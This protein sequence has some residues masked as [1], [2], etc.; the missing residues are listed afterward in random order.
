[1]TDL[2]F[3]NIRAVNAEADCACDTV[4]ISLDTKATV[5]IGEFS[6]NGKSRGLEA[7]KA[8]D[9]DMMT[10]VKVAPGGILE[11]ATGQ[12]F[13]FF[14]KSSKTSDF[15]A[16]GIDL[17]W[18][19][20][21]GTSEHIKRVVINMDNGPECSG[22]RS[23]F[24]HRMVQFA[25]SQG[26]EVRLVYYPPY[27]SKYNSIEHYW[28]GLERSWNGYLLDSVETVLKRASNFVWRSMR[29]MTTLLEGVYEKGK[30][31]CGKEKQALEKRLKRSASLPLYD[32]T[33][34]PN[35]VN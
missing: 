5:N 26:I 28:G 27:H 18:R 34:K 3:E 1:L 19:N 23:Q 21:A 8:I 12:P 14:T 25:D 15:I 17:W 31:V 32:I 13:V 10:K 16:D 2:I 20:R 35:M 22:R 6:R 11:T 33:I 4:R 30:K 7:V 29:T 9:H 24:L